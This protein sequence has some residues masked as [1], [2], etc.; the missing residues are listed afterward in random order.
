M[1]VTITMVKWANGSLGKFV[2]I[3]HEFRSRVR[4]MKL[5]TKHYY[6]AEK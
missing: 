4:G 6:V 1:Y 2:G 3:E 5:K